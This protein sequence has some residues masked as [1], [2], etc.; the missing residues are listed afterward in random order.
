MV[1]YLVNVVLVKTKR[2]LIDVYQEL[3]LANFQK[4]REQQLHKRKKLLEK[5]VKQ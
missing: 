4:H 2:I 3:K 1:Q 5:E